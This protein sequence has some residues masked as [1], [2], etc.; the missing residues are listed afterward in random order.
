MQ[1]NESGF[2]NLFLTGDWTN[3]GLNIGH[4][5]GA[6]VSGLRTGQ[7]VLKTYGFNNLRPILGDAEQI[8]KLEAVS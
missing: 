4:M 2:S 8:E 5:E 7:I 3:F 1:A 6:I